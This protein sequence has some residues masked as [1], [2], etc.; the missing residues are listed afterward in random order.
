[1]KCGMDTSAT[2]SFVSVY[3]ETTGVRM[4]PIPNPLIAAMT[5]P[6]TDARKSV[7]WK[8][9]TAVRAVSDSS[10]FISCRFRRLVCGL[11]RISRELHFLGEGESESAQK[12]QPAG[13]KCGCHLRPP[14]PC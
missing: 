1:M 8:I 12:H 6:A 13:Q 10:S 4:L 7:I 5:P 9:C 11:V 14:A 2:A 3:V